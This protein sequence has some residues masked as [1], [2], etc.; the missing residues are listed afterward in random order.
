[1]ICGTGVF[2]SRACF[3]ASNLMASR[4]WI[5]WA[6]SRMLSMG[7]RSQA[8]SK[9]F[10]YSLA[11]RRMGCSRGWGAYSAPVLGRW[12]SD[13]SHRVALAQP[14]AAGWLRQHKEHWVVAAPLPFLL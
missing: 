9:L 8:P 6:L 13:G 5:S 3:S 10:Q 1:M 7:S 2:R 12:A 11:F 4:V 14:Q